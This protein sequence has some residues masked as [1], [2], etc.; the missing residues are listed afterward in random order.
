MVAEVL[1]GWD[2]G[3]PLLRWAVGNLVFMEDAKQ[4]ATPQG[5]IYR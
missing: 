4:P 5:E 3:N 1:A 2:E